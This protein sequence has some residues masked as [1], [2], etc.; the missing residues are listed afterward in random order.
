MSDEARY[1]PAPIGVC[2]GCKETQSYHD[3]D[4]MCSRTWHERGRKLRRLAGD[5]K[6]WVETWS[7]EHGPY[8]SPEEAREVKLALVAAGW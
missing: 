6:W 8:D 2:P 3:E 1:F 5:A 4:P 7:G